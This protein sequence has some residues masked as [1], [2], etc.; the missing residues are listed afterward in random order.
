MWNEQFYLFVEVL[1]KLYHATEI[2]EELNPPNVTK[3][4]I[5]MTTVLPVGWSGS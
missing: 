5:I 4:D 2:D 1:E 3:S